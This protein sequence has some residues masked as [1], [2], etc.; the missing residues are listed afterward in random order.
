MLRL[1]DRNLI[2]AL[3]ALIHILYQRPTPRSVS[4]LTNQTPRPGPE[5]HLISINLIL[6]LRYCITKSNNQG[7]FNTQSHL[8]PHSAI[9]SVLLQVLL[10][11]LGLLKC[12]F[13]KMLVDWEQ[14]WEWEFL[15][16]KYM[17]KREVIIIYLSW[18][19]VLISGNSRSVNYSLKNS[20]KC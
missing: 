4:D 3:C 7:A 13:S 11:L 19:K 15:L 12:C 9:T 1:R 2:R 14:K 20:G 10:R 5:R 18:T 16:E 8:F 6:F 17:R